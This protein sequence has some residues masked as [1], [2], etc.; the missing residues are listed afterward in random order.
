MTDKWKKC[1]TVHNDQADLLGLSVH[2]MLGCCHCACY[3]YLSPFSYS[4]EKKKQSNSVW[5]SYVWRHVH[6]V[7]TLS[8]DVELAAAVHAA[9]GSV[10]L[11]LLWGLVVVHHLFPV[12]LVRSQHATHVIKTR[13]LKNTNTQTSAHVAS[14]W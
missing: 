1:F 6:L 10:A 2:V 12:R 5:L 7:L 11:L 9:V 3:Q 14:Q 4:S 13:R 8:V